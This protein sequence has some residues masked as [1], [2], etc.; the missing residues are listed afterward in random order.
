MILLSK[1]L[2]ESTFMLIFAADYEEYEKES[3]VLGELSF[4]IEE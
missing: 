1:S 2:E 4:A 3:V